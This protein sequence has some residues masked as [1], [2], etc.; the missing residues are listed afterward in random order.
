MDNAIDGVLVMDE[1][2]AICTTN[3]ACAKIF[4]THDIAP[5]HGMTMGQLV[6][7]WRDD[8]PDF[9][10]RTNLLSAELTGLREDS[11]EFPLHLSLSRFSDNGVFYVCAIVRDISKRKQAEA[12]VN[13]ANKLESIGE[14]TSGIAHNFNN[15]LTVILGCTRLLRK[16]SEDTI[17]PDNFIR[18]LD[19]I[20]TTAHRG[21]NQIGRLMTFARQHQLDTEPTDMARFIKDMDDMIQVSL[22]DGIKLSIDIADDLWAAVIDRIHFE[23]SVLNIVSNAKD[24]MPTGGTLCVEVYNSIL[25]ETYCALSPDVSPGEYICVAI[26]DSGTGMPQDVI[27][28]I[29]DPFFT[30]KDVGKGTGLGMSTVYGYLKQI[31]G[32]IHVYSED[33][34]GTTFKL[35]IPRSD[36]MESDQSLAPNLVAGPALY[37]GK[38]RHVLVVDDNAIMQDI[39]AASFKRLGFDVLTA[40]TAK[41]ARYLLQD[42]T[43]PFSLLFIDMFLDNQEHGTE[44]IS[45]LPDHRA[46]LPVL[47]TSGYTLNILAEDF[48]L[49]EHQF[50][51]KPFSSVDLSR[52]ISMALG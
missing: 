50:I 49:D 6:K 2:G 40:S 48:A 22:G 15:L 23:S 24:A 33:G 28:R 39:A 5:L 17:L 31:G 38:G 1:H 9:S 8:M 14:L 12:R 19:T 18:H 3:K 26:S 52:K 10:A 51:A 30:T 25:D 41:E 37:Q 7:E 47:Y 42:T 45:A 27:D 44:L 11:T 21:A 35:Y 13:S 29:F 34:H 16:A 32:Y 36:A 43:L 4:G 46:G 20:H